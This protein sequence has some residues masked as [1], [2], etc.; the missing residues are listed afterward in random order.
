ML[1][2]CRISTL[3]NKQASVFAVEPN[4]PACKCS[5]RRRKRA[6][7]RPVSRREKD[8]TRLPA[9]TTEPRGPK[10]Q[11]PKGPKAQKPK[12]PKAQSPKAPKAQR[13]QRLKDP[14]AQSPES[15][16]AA[17]PRLLILNLNGAAATFASEGCRSLHSNAVCLF[18][19]SMGQN[20]LRLHC[21][22]HFHPA[23]EYKPFPQAPS[24]N[25]FQAPNPPPPLRG[26]EP[27]AS[28]G[29]GGLGV[30]FFCPQPAHIGVSGIMFPESEFP[31]SC[32]RNSVSGN[33]FP[34]SS[35]GNPVSGIKS[36]F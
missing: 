23:D 9:R 3:L 12:G 36:C 28:S 22:L 1:L 35:F 29:A 19:T 4:T 34:E 5:W 7:R 27:P 24:F 25:S 18:S 30:Y 16:V 8:L 10:A 26:L 32:F 33:L 2:S 15:P 31:E 13:P 11:K 21:P 6:D 14:K 20:P 17:A